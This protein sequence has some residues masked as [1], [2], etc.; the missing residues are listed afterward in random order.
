MERLVK[1]VLDN[2]TEKKTIDVCGICGG[3]NSSCVDCAGT[4]YGTKVVD[5]CG[6]CGGYNLCYGCDGLIYLNTTPK[7]FDGC[8]ICGGNDS[9]LGCDGIPYS[10]SVVDSCGVCNGNNSCLGCDG[11]PYSNLTDDACGLCGGKNISCEGCDG[12]P[13]SHLQYDSCGVCGGNNTCLINPPTPIINGTISPLGIGLIAGAAGVAVIAGIAIFAGVM[14]YQGVT[15]GA[16][17][18]VPQDLLSGNTVQVNPH[19]AGEDGKSINPLAKRK[20][21][22]KKEEPIDSEEEEIEV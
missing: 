11:V 21:Q 9:C 16:L 13:N 12:V 3:D 18:F 19:Y 5:N 17:W 10:Y 15:A 6:I 1:I 22:K 20:D 2:H 7:A 4:L 14:I 8:G